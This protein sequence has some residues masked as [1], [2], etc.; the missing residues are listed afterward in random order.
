VARKR[1]LVFAP[2]TILKE[3][4][5][6][7]P[8]H[9]EVVER[10][11][12]TPIALINLQEKVLNKRRPDEVI[13]LCTQK[14]RE[15]VLSEIEAD[16]DEL[17]IDVKPL[18][19]PDG[20][21]EEELRE[22]VKTLLH[23][24]PPE[25]E[26][27]VD[28]T[29]GLRSIPFLFSVAVQYLSFLR[30]SVTIEGLYYGMM[31]NGKGQLVDLQVFLDLMDWLYAV[32]VFQDTFLPLKLA[33]MME[34]VSAE[35]KEAVCIKESLAELGNIME[36]C[37]PIELAEAAAAL[38]QQLNTD[39]PESVMSGVL[40]ADELFDKVAELASVFAP[41]GDRAHVPEVLD[42]K[43]I[44]RQVRV[45]DKYLEAGRLANAIGMMYEWVL[46]MIIYQNG[47]RAKWRTRKERDKAIRLRGSL[48]LPQMPNE[49]KE[50]MRRLRN[51]LNHYG[52]QEPGADEQELIRDIDIIRSDWEL[53]KAVDEQAWKREP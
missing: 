17:G 22:I 19:V 8:E 15:D 21:S 12:F 2:G 40:L 6:Y 25:C 34:S 9:P 39:L 3:S 14:V 1:I 42:R 20:K 24:I 47:D 10:A 37:L 46:T 16:F 49:A 5:Y 36:L 35:S 44:D 23:S 52:Q 28:I 29:H 48:E 30:P 31:S 41:E 18:S 4:D 38:R 51:H 43:E 27:L 50:R 33:Q 7:L 13:A 45:I 53:L 26:L 11:R 32:R